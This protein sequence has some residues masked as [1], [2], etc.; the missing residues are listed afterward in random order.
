VVKDG[1]LIDGRNRREACA[2]AGVMP[3]TVELNGQ[4]PVAFILS[5]N[6][7]RRHLTKG[8]RAMAT[9]RLYPDPAKIKRKGSGSSIA[10]DQ[11]SAYVSMA[12]T[13]LRLDPELAAA[14][15]SGTRALDDAYSEVKRRQQAM[16]ADEARMARLAESAPDLAELVREQRIN[17]TAAELERDERNEKRKRQAE[18]D[19]RAVQQI[20]QQLEDLAGERLARVVEL[21]KANPDAF[22]VDIRTSALRW[23]AVITKLQEHMK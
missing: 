19:V 11:A 7:A 12:R 4:D 16:Q 20:A 8:Q 5:T 14:V 17:L 22:G 13:V 10:E 1:M 6:V 3:H 15:L 9:A 2:L 23:L 18:A 21:H